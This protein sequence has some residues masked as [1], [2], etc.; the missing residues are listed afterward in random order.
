MT[1]PFTTYF[2][3]FASNLFK[4]VAKEFISSSLNKQSLSYKSPVNIIND[5]VF[6]SGITKS[7]IVNLCQPT[8]INRDNTLTQAPEIQT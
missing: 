7:L 2:C 4:M 6:P 3:I 1:I 5:L 8:M